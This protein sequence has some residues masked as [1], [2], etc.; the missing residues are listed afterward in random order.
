MDVLSLP[1]SVAGVGSFRYTTKLSDYDAARRPVVTDQIPLA[2]D[3]PN[4]TTGSGGEYDW[5]LPG[6]A[7]WDARYLDALA[8]LMRSITR[9]QNEEK[10]FDG[11]TPIFCSTATNRCVA[12]PHPLAIS[13][14]DP[15]PDEVEL[16][17][18]S[19]VDESRLG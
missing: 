7:P 15:S 14:P 8:D 10:C 2:Y 19:E 4:A 12:R 6:S 1:Q 13:W 5:C 16:A 11:R 17:A 18:R 3:L 9:E